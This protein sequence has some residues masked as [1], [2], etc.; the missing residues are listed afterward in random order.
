MPKTIWLLREQLVRAGAM[1]KLFERFDAALHDA[2]YL[3]MGGQII[4]ATVVAAPRQK[5]TDEEKETVRDGGT[6]S[7]W[8]KA[9]RRQKDL[10]ARWTIKRGRSK[11]SEASE[12][13]AAGVQIAVPVFGYKNHAGIDRRHGLIRRWTVTNAAAHD[14]RPFEDL[15]DPKNTASKVWADTA[16]RSAK[17]EAAMAKRSR[18]SMVHFRKPKGRALPARH[19]KANAARSAVR[20]A[21][22]HVFAGQK[23]RMK[24]FVRTVGLARAKV[25]IGM[26]N[27]AYNFSRLAWLEARATPA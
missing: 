3:A 17:N 16:Y 13:R 8:S 25:K 15:L 23:H 2:G 19:A 9:K 6:P 22:E 20:S 4:D 5:L 18:V 1:D 24:L 27:L 7:G 26:A 12:M 10:D 14:S 21:I 11:R